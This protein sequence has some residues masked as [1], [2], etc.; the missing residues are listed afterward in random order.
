[1]TLSGSHNPIRAS[2][3]DTNPTPR[4]KLPHGVQLSVASAA[5]NSEAGYFPVVRLFKSPGQV[6]ARCLRA[7]RRRLVTRVC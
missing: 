3:P 2:L 4:L 5:L 1:M 7:C 6:S